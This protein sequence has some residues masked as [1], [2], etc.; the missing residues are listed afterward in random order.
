MSAPEAAT[1][2]APLVQ[3]RGLTKDYPITRGVSRRVVGNVRAVNAVNLTIRKG[4]ILGLVGESGCGKTTTGRCVM[5]AI[6]PTSGEVL[7]SFDGGGARDL[8]AMDRHDLLK[9]RAHMR[10][11]FQDPY[12][13]LNPRM[14][15]SE[16]VREVLLLDGVSRDRAQIDERVAQ[17]LERVGLSRDQMSLYPHAFSGGQRQRIAIARALVSQPRFVVADEPV[18]ALDVSIQA[19]ILNLLMGLKREMD[20]TILFIAHNLAVVAHACDRIAVMYLGEIVELATADELHVAPRHP[21]TEALLSA[22]PEP[23]PRKRRPRI[24]LTGEIGDLS[25]LPTG[26]P[27]HPRC[28]YAK[29]ICREKKPALVETANP[30]REPHLAAC[31]FAEELNLEGCR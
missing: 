14:R 16:I 6:E 20:L 11:V 30:G 1:S 4:E 8:L 17:T 10:L 26:C 15:V 2:W 9:T 7:V 22:I 28:R 27:F 23:D 19:Q 31:H 29:D 5:R 3:V 12:S 24:T 13:S 25:N 18:S 21:Y